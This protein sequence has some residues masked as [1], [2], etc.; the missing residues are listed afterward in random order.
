MSA[1]ERFTAHRTPKPL[2]ALT[3]PQVA[4]RV[5]VLRQALDLLV[6]QTELDGA[7]PFSCRGALKAALI[8][9]EEELRQRDRTAPAQPFSQAVLE[10]AARERLTVAS[11]DLHDVLTGI[12]HDVRTR[13]SQDALTA[14]RAK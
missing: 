5:A 3:R 4:A 9:H 11:A 7:E 6:G 2:A 1:Y 8:Q 10:P 12:A 13:I 14:G